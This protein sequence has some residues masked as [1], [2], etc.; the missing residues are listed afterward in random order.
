MIDNPIHL[1][2]AGLSLD[3]DPV[4]D[5]AA[6]N[7]FAVKPDIACLQVCIPCKLKHF[8]HFENTV[9]DNRQAVAIGIGCQLVIT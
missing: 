1:Y 6:D 7:Y 2:S 4:A 9:L 8:E 3:F 5:I